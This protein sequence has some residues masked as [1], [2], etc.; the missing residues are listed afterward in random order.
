MAGSWG[1]DLWSRP[2]RSQFRTRSLPIV[3]DGG[4]ADAVNVEQVVDAVG[5]HVETGVVPG[6][7]IGILDG[8]REQVAAVGATEP[9]GSTPLAAHSVM[10]I[11]S[12]TKP[13]IAA[14]TVVL[15]EEGVLDLQ[16]S[17]E[18]YLPELAAR[19]VLRRPG[20][21]L[22]DTMPAQRSI[23]VEDLLTMR[24]G[25]GHVLDGP[26]P[27][28]DAAVAAGLGFGPPDPTAPLPPDEWIARFAAL[29]LLDQPG[30]TWR[31]E[32][33]FAV[34]GVLLSRATAMPLD[35]L[36][37][38][39]LLDPLGLSDTAFQAS[40]EALP[41]AYRL[42]DDGTLALFDGGGGASRW[43]VA[44]VFPDARGGLIS[45]AS[46]LLRF[47]GVLLAGGAPLL[48][49]ASVRAMTA[50]ALTP[51]QRAAPSAAPF[52]NGGGWGYG[53][54]VADTPG[55]RR[56]GWAGG[57]GTLWWSWPQH[58]TAAVLLTQVLPPVP[59]VFEAFTTSIESALAR[60]PPT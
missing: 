41:P 45:T 38:E 49:T 18:R 15:I 29:P 30:T 5:P 56:Y 7:V 55:G 58:D 48:S 17:V 2:G 13:F 40:A 27:A 44:P 21:D 9:G 53:I 52:L 26:S 20:A 25:F 60:Q 43:T 36:L 16:G 34:L 12:N 57:L 42:E 39:R 22:N 28:V 11:S 59:T 19:R 54:G 37:R 24:M 23:T 35:L 3:R 8:G 46:D 1:A 14:L 51:A 32:I 10:R 4:Y 33:S 31:Y 50:D 6:A 47:A